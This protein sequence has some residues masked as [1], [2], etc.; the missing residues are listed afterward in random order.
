MFL[1]GI[2]I[3]KIYIL[4]V[5]ENADEASIER[6]KWSMKKRNI[7]D[8]SYDLLAKTINTLEAEELIKYEGDQYVVTFKGRSFYKNNKENL[9][10][11]TEFLGEAFIP[12]GT[13]YSV[14]N[15]LDKILAYKT[16]PY[17]YDSLGTQT[18]EDFF[19]NKIEENKPYC[20]D[21][22]GLGKSRYSMTLGRNEYDYS[23]YGILF[24]NAGVIQFIGIV[25]S[26]DNTKKELHLEKIIKLVNPI[27]INDIRKKVRTNYNGSQQKQEFFEPDESKSL[28]LL[29]KEK[30]QKNGYVLY[31]R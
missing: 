29:V 2:N 21:N 17:R 13:E 9:L 5:F 28:T 14:P 27:S 1:T 15:E 4:H 18:E 11:L 19:S 20:F 24:T 22:R 12:E 6:I 10:L 7:T 8:V 30:I 3:L 26:Y 16:V 25:H 23:G 31:S